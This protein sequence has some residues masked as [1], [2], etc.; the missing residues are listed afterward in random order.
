MPIPNFLGKCE[1]YRNIIILQIYAHN[2]QMYVGLSLQQIYKISIGGNYLKIVHFIILISRMQYN[3]CTRVNKAIYFLLKYSETKQ[4]LALF[5]EMIIL[6]NYSGI[7]CCLW[8]DQDNLQFSTKCFFD[9]F[10][11]FFDFLLL[12]FVQF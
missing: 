3:T 10:D 9:L 12:G 5:L 4:M 11:E 6:E 8:A 2:L 1:N 7:F